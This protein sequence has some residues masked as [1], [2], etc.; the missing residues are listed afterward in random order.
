MQK[1]LLFLLIPFVLVAQPKPDYT[2]RFDRKAYVQVAWQGS[3]KPVKLTVGTFNIVPA[4]E[5][6]EVLDTLLNAKGQGV[7]SLPVRTPQQGYISFGDIQ[8]D[9][10]LMPDDTVRLSINFD[11]DTT[12]QD[13]HL[14]Y[15]GKYAPLQEYYRS[16]NLTLSRI[17]YKRAFSANNAPNLAAYQQVMDSLYRRERSFYQT[18]QHKHALP[19]WFLSDVDKQITYGDASLRE[20]TIFYRRFMNKGREEP[21]PDTYFSYHNRAPISN[22]SVVHL[23][24]YWQYLDSYFFLKSGRKIGKPYS[25][26]WITKDFEK[27]RTLLPE[28]AYDLYRAIQLS[29]VATS[30]PAEVLPLIEKLTP[31]F[32]NQKLVDVIRS[33]TKARIKILQPGDPAPSFVLSDTRDSLVSLK[34]FR[35]NVVLLCF[36]FPGC[37]PCVAEFP[38][39]NALVKQFQGKS[40][41]IVG[42]GTTNGRQMWLTAIQKHQLKTVNL[43]ANESWQ[44]SLE[45]KFGI[46]GYPHYVLIDQQGKIVKN[47]AE[48]PSQNIAAAIERLLN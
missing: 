3:L 20:N 34:E 45:Q 33:D 26:T 8:Y 48:R 13:R 43:Y 21:I 22:I 35:G 2:V 32:K 31:T 37:K 36:W 46:V 19:D 4:Y 28:S 11:Q 38:H 6:P 15:V 5:N 41:R 27:A 16:R 47:F 12:W 44:K 39:E 30:K 29:G 7:Y 1:L 10:Y 24:A 18:Y 42:I 17:N 23:G 40:V 25:N 14:T 9:L